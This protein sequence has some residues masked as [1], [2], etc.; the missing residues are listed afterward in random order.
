MSDADVARRIAVAATGWMHPNDPS[1]VIAEM[2][3]TITAQIVV[4]LA[5]ARADAA[6]H[7]VNFWRLSDVELR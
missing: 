2:T 7:S 6:R 4:A 5:N 3:E 1:S